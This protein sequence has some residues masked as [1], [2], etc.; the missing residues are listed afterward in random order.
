[1]GPSNGKPQQGLPPCQPSLHTHTAQDH[2]KAVKLGALSLKSSAKLI[3]QM[4]ISYIA[5]KMVTFSPSALLQCPR[6]PQRPPHEAHGHESSSSTPGTGKPPGHEAL[7]ESHHKTLCNHQPT[8]LPAGQRIKLHAAGVPIS[9][10]KGQCVS[11][12]GGPRGTI[13]SPAVSAVPSVIA[14]FLC[15]ST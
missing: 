10:I 12:A 1:M 2:H 4:G 11:H 5:L 7:E 13:I 3:L 15:N 9:Q 8:A 6:R 14:F